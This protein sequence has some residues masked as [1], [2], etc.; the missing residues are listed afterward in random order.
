MK[1]RAFLRVL[2]AGVLSMLLLALGGAV[3]LRAQMG[4]APAS[5]AASQYSAASQ[6]RAEAAVSWDQSK[7]A[8]FIPSRAL[9][10]GALM[11]DA[12][13]WE[14]AQI[15]AAPLGEQ[16]LLRQ[17]LGKIKR[18]LRQ[19]GIHYDRDLRPWIGAEMTAALVSLDEDRDPDNGSQPGYLL[20]IATDD[21]QASQ[22]FLRRF[23]QRRPAQTTQQAGVEI[24]HSAD[25]M[26][27]AHVG[28]QLVLIANHMSVIQDA[29]SS[30]Q[31][32]PLNIRSRQRYEAALAQLPPRIG[33]LLADLPQIRPWLSS[34]LVDL[35]RQRVMRQDLVR[36]NGTDSDWTV[37][38][39]ALLAT[40]TQADADLALQLWLTSFEALEASA[41][42]VNLE[43]A[44]LEQALDETTSPADLALAQW[45]PGTSS[46]AILDQDLSARWSSAIVDDGPPLANSVLEAIAPPDLASLGIDAR[47]IRD[48]IVPW[49][50][51]DYGIAKLRSAEGQSAKLDWIFVT[52]ASAEVM[53]GLRDLDARAQSQGLTVGVIPYANQQLTVWTKLSAGVPPSEPNGDIPSLIAAVKGVHAVVDDTA[54]IATS[55]GAIAQAL[56]TADTDPIGRAI[57][58]LGSSAGG[59]IHLAW[60]EVRALAESSRGRGMDLFETLDGVV[61]SVTFTRYGSGAADARAKQDPFEQDPFEQDP[62]SNRIGIFFNLQG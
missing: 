2:L 53:D 44:D 29:I 24:T 12:T 20:A 56:Q 28:R 21:P 5:S 33:F 1:F 37:Q 14:I 48:W 22:A 61:E 8:A 34:D 57:A 46:A 36:E 55:V 7:T 31:V 15:A 39:S 16:R 32:P 58:T 42:K 35:M 51:G 45:L 25:G 19:F 47:E 4:A 23:W 49:V 6:S 27:T 43:E 60:P 50:S 62:D 17:Q 18:R 40:V 59:Y 26:S 41:G 13:D 11:V 52:P 3:W 38:H 9:A 30:A 54:L 10:L